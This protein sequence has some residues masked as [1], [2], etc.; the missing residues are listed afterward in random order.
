MRLPA[1]VGMALLISSVLGSGCVHSDPL[2]DDEASDARAA[3]DANGPDARGHEDRAMEAGPAAHDAGTPTVDAGPDGSSLLP[4][5][6]TVGPNREVG[7][8]CPVEAPS[9]DCPAAGGWA[10]TH[11]ECRRGPC[12]V[13][14]PS[15]EQAVD[16][17][18]CSVL[19]V[20]GDE[21]CIGPPPHHYDA[22]LEDASPVDASQP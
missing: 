7:L 11:A 8:C 12:D 6:G 5:G 4:E 20:V 3:S 1:S 16:D 22:G 10:R 18:G 14:P 13:A 21:S 15:F 19:R 17:Y 2:P 9:C